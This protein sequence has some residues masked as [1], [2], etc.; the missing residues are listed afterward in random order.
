MRPIEAK[1]LK[2]IK[3]KKKLT[4]DQIEEI[5]DSTSKQE[6][7]K[8]FPDDCLFQTNR[9]FANFLIKSL[10]QKKLIKKENNEF[11]IIEKETKKDGDS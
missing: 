8:S 1:I 7:K 11:H 4:F 3:D 10:A 6:L 5:I 2:I 9:Y